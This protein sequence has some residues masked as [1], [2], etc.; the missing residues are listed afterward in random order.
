V[1]VQLHPS[2]DLDTRYRWLLETWKA[3]QFY[4]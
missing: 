2:F 3:L 4:C 1:E